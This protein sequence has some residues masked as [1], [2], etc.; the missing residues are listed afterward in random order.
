MR[1]IFVFAICDLKFEIPVF[2]LFAP[3]RA[4]RGQIP[5]LKFDL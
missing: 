3:F 2:L 5:I 4:F 1:E